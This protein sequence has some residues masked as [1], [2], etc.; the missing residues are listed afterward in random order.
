MRSL[1]KSVCLLAL[2]L[3]SF[4]IK[5]QDWTFLKGYGKLPY[6]ATYGTQGV[7]APG[8]MPGARTFPVTWESG[9]KMYLFGGNGNTESGS[10][11]LNDLWEYDPAT[12]NWTWLKGSNLTNQTGVYGTI[13][14]ASA[15]NNP[16]SRQAA[17]SW[18]SGG[19][20]YLFGGTGYASATYGRLNDLWVYDIATGNW[21]WIKGSDTRN[22]AAV[23][24]VI[25]TP[26]PSND[27]GNREYANS[28]SLGGK[29][30]LFGGQE[31]S[32]G[33]RNDL[34]EFDITT[35]N[36]TWLKGS[37]ID[38]QNGI[39]G[40]LNTPN[41]SNNPGSRRDATT[42]ASGG[43]LYLFGGYG[44]AAAGIGGLN[45][46]WEYDPATNNWTWIKGSNSSSQNGVYGTLN[47]P[48]INNTPSARLHGEGWESDGKLYL[49]GG[50]SSVSSGG[51]INDLWVFDL[52]TRNWAWI[53]GSDAPN[54]TGTYGTLNTPDAG[55][56]P[57]ARQFS[58]NWKTGGKLYLFGGNVVTSAGNGSNNDL[59]S[60]DLATGNWTWLK[61]SNV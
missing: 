40:T 22:L 43:K 7:A 24:G 29:L 60:Y 47:T 59:W 51:A 35:G 26:A 54:Q 17:S 27:P 49:F 16:G 33:S 52:A 39:Y 4:T 12:G 30:Y 53:N 61:G 50:F 15:S 11:F 56:V 3:I 9:G 8:N 44:N 28:W 2:L 38:G 34:W 46:L 20:L 31:I 1:F 10:G 36:W 57:G 5:A 19:K 37:N 45:D 6:Y 41:A 58:A 42:W 55:N 21:T 14:T 18:E 25:N 23:Y 13:N 32:S 48:N